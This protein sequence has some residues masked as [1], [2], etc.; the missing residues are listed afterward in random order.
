MKRYEDDYRSSDSR[1]RRGEPQEDR[2]PR[3][4]LETRDSRRI[5]DDHPAV[6]DTRG[7]DTRGD[8]MD[9]TMDT[10]IPRVDPIRA[11]A[12]ARV[13]PRP[14]ERY[15]ME[16]RPRGEP[17]FYK[18]PRTGELRDARTGELYQE[19]PPR[20]VYGRD[21]RM[22]RDRMER[23]DIPIPPSSR[24]TREVV[25]LAPPREYEDDYRSGKKYNDYFVPGTGLD[26]EVIQH[27][28]CRYLGNDA[29]VRPFT[30]KDVCWITTPN[31]ER[32]TS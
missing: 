15:G 16:P 13:E 27:E 22:D 32:L 24:R 3:E 5:I 1:R 7:I 14:T 20:P 10:R 19:A 12:A 4:R 2:Q 18:D 30:N 21:D 17:E 29:T 26:R 28:I 23:D 11:N 8:R 6:R 25:D 9:T 31:E